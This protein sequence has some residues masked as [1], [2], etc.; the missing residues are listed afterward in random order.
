MSPRAE[1]VPYAGRY[2][3]I[4]CRSW[5][6]R[7]SNPRP[8]KEPESFLHA[9]PSKNPSAAA[10]SRRRPGRG[11]SPLNFAAAYGH[12]GA[13]SVSMIPRALPATET[14]RRRGTRSTVSSDS[15]IKP[16]YLVKLGSECVAII[17]ICSSSIQFYESLHN[18]RH[19]YHQ[20]LPAV[21]TGQPLGGVLHAIR[22][23]PVQR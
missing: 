20:T 16:F 4:R 10:E 5:S 14:S 21:K 15:G 1:R 19:A 9:Y 11:P 18:A 6:W 12:R 7:E 13:I 3:G 23:K 2:V 22:T 8:N 17:A